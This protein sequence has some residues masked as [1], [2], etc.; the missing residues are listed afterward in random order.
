MNSSRT[1]GRSDSKGFVHTWFKIRIPSTNML[2]LAVKKIFDVCCLV[3]K[4]FS[5]SV[6][7]SWAVC[8]FDLF[9]PNQ[10]RVTPIQH[11]LTALLPNVLQLLLGHLAEEGHAL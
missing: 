6:F 3:F 8:S 11:L 4:Q 7:H 9:V 10:G 5:S 2:S 1:T